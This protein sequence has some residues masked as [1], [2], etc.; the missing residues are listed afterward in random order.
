MLA[1]LHIKAFNESKQEIANQ[2]SKAEDPTSAIDDAAK[3]CMTKFVES[4]EDLSSR[5]SDLFNE[6]RVALEIELNAIAEIIAS[7]IEEKRKRGEAECA[8]N[9]AKLKA[10][11]AMTQVKR[12]KETASL[13]IEQYKREV[14]T[15]RSEAQ[16]SKEETKQIAKQSIEEI[17][18]ISRLAKQET[19]HVKKELE[20]VKEEQ[21]KEREQAKEAAEVEAR[22]RAN[23]MRLDMVRAVVVVARVV[24]FRD[25]TVIVDILDFALWHGKRSKGETQTLG[26]DSGTHNGKGC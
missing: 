20:I 14:A 18:R 6:H 26:S 8:K 25:P 22:R 1:G 9:E 11:D 12:I 3:A 17:H 2:L 10:Q 21:G 16:R 4:C 15:A 23:H 13:E 5:Y 19:E 24:I 7:N